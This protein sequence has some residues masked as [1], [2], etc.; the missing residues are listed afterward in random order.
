MTKKRRNNGCALAT[1]SLFAAQTVPYV[2]PR[3]RPL[4]NS[5]SKTVEVAA[6]RDISEVSV[7]DAYVPLK[8]FVK[9]HY[10]MSY[11]IHSK[12]VRNP[13]HEACKDQTPPTLI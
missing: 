3:T 4:R 12:V 1:C 7:F 13:S 2:C 9:L 10:C 5:S 6:V 11:A 8:L